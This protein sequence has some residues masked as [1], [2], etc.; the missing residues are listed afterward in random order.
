MRLAG[1]INGSLHRLEL[2]L[3]WGHP[4]ELEALV[5]EEDDDGAAS[6]Q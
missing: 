4:V 1:L 5:A 3:V 6:L 2:R